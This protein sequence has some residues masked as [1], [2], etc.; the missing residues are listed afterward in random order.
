MFCQRLQPRE[1]TVNMP[2]GNLIK[3]AADFWSSKKKQLVCVSAKIKG[4]S[5]PWM[6]QEDDRDT[7]IKFLYPAFTKMRRAWRE[8]VAIKR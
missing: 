6:Q 8:L 1:K 5:A 7:K 2:K 3:K 4:N